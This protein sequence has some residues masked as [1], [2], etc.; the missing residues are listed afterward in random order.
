MGK[1]QLVASVAALAVLF[2]GL[3]IH[4]FI[5]Q[6]GPVDPTSTLVLSLALCAAALTAAAYTIRLM[7][8][9]QAQQKATFET[10]VSTLGHD[11]RGPLHEVHTAVS[12]L[13]TNVTEQ[14]KTELIST[15]IGSVSA[16]TRQIDDVVRITR[17]QALPWQPAPVDMG[18]WFE[19]FSTIYHPKAKSS[20]LKWKATFG[21]NMPVLDV[22]S[23]RLTQSV[24]QLV[25]NAIR[26]TKSG[27]VS[28]ELAYSPEAREFTATVQDTGPGIPARDQKRIL[29]A[30]ERG[31]GNTTGRRRLGIGLTVVAAIAKAAHGSVRF[32]SELG[33]GST[34]TLV[35]PASVGKLPL[36]PVVQDAPKP[37]DAPDSTIGGEVLLVDNKD[38]VLVRF[39]TLLTDA[40]FAVEWTPNEAEGLA[41]LAKAPF[42][43]VVSCIE[44]E[45][46]NGFTYA[47]AHKR[48]KEKPYFIGVNTRNKTFV[49]TERYALFDAMIEP[50]ISDEAF[51]DAVEKGLKKD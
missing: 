9:S 46:V 42:G 8:N 1:N 50:S 23:D 2:A 47:D 16:I 39:G 22:D 15:A 19:Q 17:G 49:G 12:L 20:E 26:Y 41:R 36:P 37:S 21:A 32:T 33:S 35:L 48:P 27:K 38:Q 18:E 28:V 7:L 30:F 10:L 31:V 51:T 24:G 43:V 14:E 25:D 44:T 5:T 34:F 13:G 6:A 40:G 11:L 4:A 3:L 29:H 45:V